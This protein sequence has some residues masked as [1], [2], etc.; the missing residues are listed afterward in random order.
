MK[1]FTMI[2]ALVV[3]IAMPMF[4]ERV[5]PETARKVATT[6]LNNNGAKASQ[7]TD[8][9]KEAGFSNLYIFNGNPGFVV[10]A[11]DDCVQPILGYSLTGHSV[12]K[13]CPPT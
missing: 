5:Q 1:R 6:F 2:V 13:T 8:L 9:T 3:I 7:L 10:M 4:A 12:R 11:A